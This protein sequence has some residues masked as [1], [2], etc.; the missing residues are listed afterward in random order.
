MPNGTSWT[1][2]GKDIYGEAA[3][4]YL[5]TVSMNVAGD[6]V[7]IGHG[8]DGNGSNAGQE[9]FMPTMELHGYNKVDIDGEASDNSGNRNHECCRR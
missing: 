7:A 5:D 6:R 2:Q 4:D 1:Q 3:G 9:E 8:N